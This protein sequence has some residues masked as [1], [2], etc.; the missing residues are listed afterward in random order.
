LSELGSSVVD[1][2]VA[3]FQKSPGVVARTCRTTV[4]LPWCGTSLRSQETA[5]A[6]PHDFAPDDETSSKLSGSSS[7]RWTPVASP[8]PRF[9]IRTL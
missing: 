6:R 8:G 3:V 7:T 4:K 2:A 5:A 1:D 9:R